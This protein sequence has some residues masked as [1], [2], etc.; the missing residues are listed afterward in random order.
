MM[1]GGV[2]FDSKYLMKINQLKIQECSDVGKAPE[3]ESLLA[4]NHEESPS[5]VGRVA[6]TGLASYIVLD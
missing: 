4:P 5:H 2:H 1:E 3:T 6:F